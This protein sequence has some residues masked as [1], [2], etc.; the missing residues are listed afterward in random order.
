MDS[1]A[2]SLCK[3]QQQIPVKRVKPPLEKLTV[4]K[5]AKSKDPLLAERQ[6]TKSSALKGTKRRKKEE[7][8]A[9]RIF[10]VR[11]LDS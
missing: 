1:E 2:K 3:L 11:S 7:E 6:K 4:P 9:E 8:E 10:S 5:R